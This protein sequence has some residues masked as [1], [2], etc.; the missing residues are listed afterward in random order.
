LTWAMPPD[1][2]ERFFLK[3]RRALPNQ[4]SP[5]L[6]FSWRALVLAMRNRDRANKNEIAA[7]VLG[8]T[9]KNFSHVVPPNVIAKRSSVVGLQSWRRGYCLDAGIDPLTPYRPCAAT[10]PL[11]RLCLDID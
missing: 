11:G 5:I 9:T 2:T 6:P 3:D 8:V 7:F 4:M 1:L 10:V